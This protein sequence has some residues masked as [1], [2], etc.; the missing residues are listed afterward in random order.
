M[1]FNKVSDTINASE[2]SVVV[3]IDGVNKTLAQIEE[4]S[5][6]LA[7]STAKVDLIGKPMTGHKP[8]S[9]EGTGKLK[10]FLVDNTLSNMVLNFLS[11]G[12]YPQISITT[13]VEDKS[14][15]TGKQVVQLIGVIF[16]TATLF[17]MLSKDALMEQ[18]SN[19][20]FDD[21]KMINKF[22]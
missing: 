7:L 4:I 9:L 1:A 2:G 5:A 16:E 10:M 14:S 15:A 18:S 21:V 20:T 12:K 19:F 11:T 17:D 13:T 6:E 8:L 22:S 3:T